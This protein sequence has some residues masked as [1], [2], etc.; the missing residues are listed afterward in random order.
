VC[1]ADSV[2]AVH[3]ERL[4]LCVGAAASGGVSQVTKTHEARKIRD[5][6][7]VVEDLGGHAVALALVKATASAATDYAGR[8]LAAV[9]EEI[10]RIVDLDRRRLRFPL[11]L[12]MLQLDKMGALTGR[13][14]SQ[15]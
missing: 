14:G 3:I 7:A 4:C 6:S 10:Q 2:R 8:I 5:A 1:H 11:L 13:R 15:Q 9:L 12:S